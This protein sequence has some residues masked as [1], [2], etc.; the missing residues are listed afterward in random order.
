MRAK[1]FLREDI[2]IPV[3]KKDAALAKQAKHL[4]MKSMLATKTSS[5]NGRC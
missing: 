4:K 5:N 1:D 3:T 2:P